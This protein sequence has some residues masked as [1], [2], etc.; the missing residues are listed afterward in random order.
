MVGAGDA[1]RRARLRALRLVVGLTLEELADRTGT[2]PHCLSAYERGAVESKGQTLVKLVAVFGPTPANSASRWWPRPNRGKQG[3]E[4][5][6]LR[7]PAG[8]RQLPRG[9]AASSASG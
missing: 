6:Q 8:A 2:C 5:L 3:R 1:G 9:L 4:A 7:G